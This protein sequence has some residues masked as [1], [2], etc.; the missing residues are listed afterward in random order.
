MS[1]TISVAAL[2]IRQL[3]LSIVWETGLVSIE[4]ELFVLRRVFDL[5]RY[6]TLAISDAESSLRD[7][8][9]LTD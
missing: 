8:R 4:P 9:W 6:I 2:N 3:Q 5:W 7:I 1:W